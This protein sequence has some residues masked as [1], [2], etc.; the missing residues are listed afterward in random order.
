MLNREGYRVFDTLLRVFSGLSLLCTI[1]TVW[2]VRMQRQ[3]GPEPS[4]HEV[5]LMLIIPAQLILFLVCAIIAVILAGLGFR[6]GL[7]LS[8]AGV[9]MILVAICGLVV[10]IFLAR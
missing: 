3:G 10:E 5:S 6:R 9:A 7:R 8:R 2:V 1:Y 4:V